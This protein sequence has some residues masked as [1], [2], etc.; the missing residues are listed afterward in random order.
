M[1]IAVD[2]ERTF[3]YVLQEERDLPIEQQTVWKIKVLTARELAE[4]EDNTSRIDKEGVLQVRHGSVVLNTLRKGLRGWE[5]FQDAQGNPVPFRDNNGVPREDNFDR[6]RPA[7][8]REICNA[9][10]EQNR[11]TA[12]QVK[13]SA[14]GQEFPK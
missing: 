7:W 14:S 13:N 6:M 2:P 11:L 4:I 3:D 1:A 12:D 10:T 9:I 5:N 8:R